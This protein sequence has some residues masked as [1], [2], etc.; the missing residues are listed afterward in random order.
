[1]PLDVEYPEDDVKVTVPGGGDRKK[2]VDLSLKNANFFIQ[3][4]RRK[5]MLHLGEGQAEEELL[6]QLQDDLS[7]QDTPRHIECFDNSN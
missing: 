6:M 5:K 3:E 2:L 7:L 4:S 1:M